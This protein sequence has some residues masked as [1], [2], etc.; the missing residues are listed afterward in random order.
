MSLG[1]KPKKPHFPLSAQLKE[2]REKLRTHRV[3][4][5]SGV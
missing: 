5:A 4:V 3:K 2:L 1:K